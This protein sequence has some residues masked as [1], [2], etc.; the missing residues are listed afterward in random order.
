MIVFFEDMKADLAAVVERVADF[1]GLDTSAERLSV[2]TK[3]ASFAFMKEHQLQFNESLTKK[4]R[5]AAC[6]LPADAGLRPG[7]TKVREGQTGHQLP[8]EIR[9]EIEAKWRAVVGEATGCA[10][11]A[12]LRQTFGLASK[13]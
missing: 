3:H 6:N 13:S 5:N 1:M 10:T 12:Q 7:Q 4:A 8:D 9:E 2:A 11:Y